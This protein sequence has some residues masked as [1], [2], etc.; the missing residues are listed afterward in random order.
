MTR[1]SN[2]LNAA[3]ARSTLVIRSIVHLQNNSS[4]RGGRVLDQKFFSSSRKSMKVALFLVFATVQVIDI[5]QPVVTTFRKICPV[6][7]FPHQV[8]WLKEYVSVF[9]FSSSRARYVADLKFVRLLSFRPIKMSSKSSPLTFFQLFEYLQPLWLLLAYLANDPNHALDADIQRYPSSRL[10]QGT[11]D[12][13]LLTQSNTRY[14]LQ[15]GAQPLHLSRS[16][17]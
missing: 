13:Q 1:C 15:V 10:D 5:F 8:E 3:N 11:P 14:F 16:V 17:K 12:K 2:K 4:S 6:S 7:V 9:Q